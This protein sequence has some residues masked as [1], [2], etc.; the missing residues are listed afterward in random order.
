MG[1]FFMH[2]LLYSYP[3]ASVCVVLQLSDFFIRTGS[4]PMEQPAWH[5]LLASTARHPCPLLRLARQ[6]HTRLR[7]VRPA[8]TLVLPVSHALTVPPVLWTVALGSTALTERK[9]ARWVTV[10]FMLSVMV[11]V[12]EVVVVVVVVVVMML[13]L[14]GCLK[15]GELS[16][17]FVK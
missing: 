3:H 15:A 7:L 10:T 5:V 2:S 1:G 8:A 16:S 12:V 9:C 17:S 14:G 11:V 4:T 13:L 6:A